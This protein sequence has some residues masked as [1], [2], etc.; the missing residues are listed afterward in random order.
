MCLDYMDYD[1]WAVCPNEIRY[2]PH[3]RITKTC[4]E[5]LVTC[6]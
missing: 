1:I 4:W 3:C 2:I 5:T 6:F